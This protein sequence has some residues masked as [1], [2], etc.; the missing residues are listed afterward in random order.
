MGGACSM[1]GE[2]RGLYRALVGKP[3]GNKPLGR[4]RNRREDNINMGIQERG[5]GLDRAGSE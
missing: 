2:R 4:H 5:Y 3:V 1:C